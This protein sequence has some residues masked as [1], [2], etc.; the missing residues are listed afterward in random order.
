M[1]D[2]RTA[3][4]LAF[5]F[6]D[7]HTLSFKAALQTAGN[8]LDAM[9]VSNAESVYVWVSIDSPLSWFEKYTLDNKQVFASTH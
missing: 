8:V 6:S 3:L 4:L 9:I 1:V 2:F 5:S 7:E